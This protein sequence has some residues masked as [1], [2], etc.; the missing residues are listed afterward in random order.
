[1]IQNIKPLATRIERQ[2]G[3]TE[4]HGDAIDHPPRPVEHA[5]LARAKGCDVGCAAVGL[6]YQIQRLRQTE[7]SFLRRTAVAAASEMLI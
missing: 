6:K 5:D 2:P 7:I 3:R 4:A 1:M